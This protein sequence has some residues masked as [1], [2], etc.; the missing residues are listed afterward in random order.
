MKKSELKNR[1]GFNWRD[2]GKALG[3][4]VISSILTFVLKSL[5]AGAIVWD[6]KGM[7][8]AS[9]TGALAYISITF[10]NPKQNGK[11]GSLEH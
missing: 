7:V 5:D 4:A 9:I 6:W 8:I 2:T 10:F 1:I 3:V 11:D